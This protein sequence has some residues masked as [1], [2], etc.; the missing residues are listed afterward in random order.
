MAGHGNRGTVQGDSWKG[1][2]SWTLTHSQACLSHPC[3]CRP[4]A[5]WCSRV[6]TL[7]ARSINCQRCFWQLLPNFVKLIVSLMLSLVFSSAG[8]SGSLG[9]SATTCHS[10]IPCWKCLKLFV[11]CVHMRWLHECVTQGLNI[12]SSTAKAID[13]D[14]LRVWFVT[15]SVFSSNNIQWL[16]LPI[17]W[18][19]EESRLHMFD[20]ATKMKSFRISL[21]S[22]QCEHYHTPQDS[23]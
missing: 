16:S 9:F 17:H 4:S 7:R 1:R 14:T 11:S 6:L 5:S 10:S 2:S 20:V 3:S 15:L 12:A 8:A 23:Y 13:D 18:P 22:H 19:N 21:W